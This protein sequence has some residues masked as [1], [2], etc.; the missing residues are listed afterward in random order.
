MLK[1]RYADRLR[2]SL[3]AV[4]LT[5]ES[6]ERVMAKLS[7]SVEYVTATKNID[8]KGQLWDFAGKITELSTLL[9]VQRDRMIR[10]AEERPT[11]FYQSPAHIHDNVKKM[12]RTLGVDVNTCIHAMLGKPQ[13]ITMNP[14]S[15][16]DK[17]RFIR[18]AHANGYIKSHD[19]V[20]DILANPVVLTYGTDNTHLRAIQAHITG[21]ARNLSCYFKGCYNERSRVEGEVVSHF[22]KI[23]EDSAGTRGITTVKRLAQAGILSRLPDWAADRPALAA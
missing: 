3:A 22:Q 6:V 14:G 10:A 17:I 21:K 9:G 15:I 12:A 11:L 20:A 2:E 7:R 23:F 8:V 13:T 1:P 16:A 19:I 4:P 18:D 5:P